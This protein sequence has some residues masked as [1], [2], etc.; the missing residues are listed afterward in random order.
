QI[1]ELAI[2]LLCF[3]KDTC[4][5]VGIVD[6]YCGL[7]EPTIPIPAEASRINGIYMHDVKGKDLDYEQVNYLFNKADFFISH[8]ADF[9]RSFVRVL[10][11][12]VDSK[13][14]LCSVNGINWYGKGSYS[15]GLQN[16]LSLHSIRPRSA[17]RASGDVES[18]IKLLACTAE[19]G[20]SYFSELI[21]GQAK[22]Q[23]PSMTSNL[24][25]YY[26]KH[27]TEY[28]EIVKTLRRKEKED[29]KYLK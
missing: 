16:L 20:E 23:K 14:W 11:P 21:K 6:S 4:K 25:Y 17:H 1:I 2:S 13:K 28:K 24:G 5:I 15:K 27:Y 10:F 3:E 29:L 12:S 18:T 22:F 19:N 26:G 7:R 9:D 8:N